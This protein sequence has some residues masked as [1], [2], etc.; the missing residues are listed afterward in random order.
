MMSR[1]PSGPRAGSTIVAA[2]RDAMGSDR[3]RSYAKQWPGGVG[4]LGLKRSY[5]VEES[6]LI[7]GTEQV[8]SLD[9]RMRFRAGAVVE[10]D[11]LA[12]VAGAAVVQE[13]DALAG[14]P[15]GSG[16]EHVARRQT[17]VDVVRQILAHVVKREVGI[18]KVLLPGHSPVRRFA[19]GEAQSGS[20]A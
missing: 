9:H 2:G 15:Q 12:E 7:V 4:L 18:G 20:V 14:A 19:R 10:L 1:R 11:G 16:A 13:E 6:L 8:E 5:E 17:L 3:P